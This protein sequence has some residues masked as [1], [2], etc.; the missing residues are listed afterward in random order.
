MLFAAWLVIVAL[1]TLTTVGAVTTTDDGVAI[2]TGII[3]FLLFGVAAF[4]AFDL[5]I[6]TDSGSIVSRTETVTAGVMLTVSLAPGW[7]ALTGP[8][9]IVQR[10]RQTEME[11]V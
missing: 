4:G 1:A 5:A 10:V 3:G 11:D 9:Q 6:V 8:V 2:L 7:I